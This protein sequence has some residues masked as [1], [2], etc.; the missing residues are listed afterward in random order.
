MGYGLTCANCIR[1]A[2]TNVR[3]WPGSC[4]GISM[5]S[6]NRSNSVAA[7][8]SKLPLN[9][10]S[11]QARAGRDDGHG[12]WVALP[13]PDASAPSYGSRRGLALE[14]AHS[15]DTIPIAAAL[16]RARTIGLPRWTHHIV[17]VFG[18]WAAASLRS[19]A[20]RR[21][22]FQHSLNCRVRSVLLT[23]EARNT[24]F[25]LPISLNRVD[26]LLIESARVRVGVPA[27]PS[28]DDH[29]EWLRAV[30]DVH[31]IGD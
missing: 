12:A 20:N 2:V 27:V 26:D 21:P 25:M 7:R 31:S 8:V 22:T 15:R 3:Q 14:A 11:H 30:E 10:A 4:D 17:A 9:C 5:R 24:P 18:L 23:A 19:A 13:E 1:G 29:T 6:E 28:H 16:V